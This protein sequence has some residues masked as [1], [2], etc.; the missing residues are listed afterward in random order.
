MK[1]IGLTGGI[2]SGKSL[3]A[4]IFDHLGVPVYHADTESR[5]I[6][7]ED[8]EIRQVLTDWFGPAIYGRD[9]LDRPALAQIL[10]SDRSW[11]DRINGLV[12]PKV[13]GHFM[14]WCDR[15][16]DHPYV[17]HEAAILFETGLDRHMDLNILVTAPEELRVE[18][19]VRRDHTTPELVRQ[20]IRNQMA[21]EVKIPLA[22]FVIPNDGKSAVIPLILE[23]HKKLTDN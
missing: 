19:V 2:G 11:L 1:I 3:I 13:M 6:M 14:T 17:L 12:H 5:R 23:I 8:P 10:F 20:R 16:R 9:G 21:D 18:R 22:D 4:G 15:Y 7:N